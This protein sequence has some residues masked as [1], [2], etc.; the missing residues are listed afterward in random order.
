MLRVNPHPSLDSITQ[1]LAKNSV[2]LE[3]S[4]SE[5]DNSG[6]SVKPAILGSPDSE[7]H[8]LRTRDVL[9]SVGLMT[10]LYMP[11]SMPIC[12]IFA[13]DT[14]N[15]TCFSISE[16]HANL[17]RRSLVEVLRNLGDILPIRS[18][19][20]NSEIHSHML[21]SDKPPRA[22]HLPA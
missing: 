14:E 17:A 20:G 22:L 15:A 21:E 3:A 7:M 11:C 4:N 1:M 19:V 8:N 16:L 6:P 13:I 18:D 10:M 5:I 9:A 2:P 12:D